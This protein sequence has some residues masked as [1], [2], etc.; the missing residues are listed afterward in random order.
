MRMLAR[1]ENNLLSL[2]P[3]VA[4]REM[5]TSLGMSR[6]GIV[7]V[8]DPALVAQVMDADAALFPK[9][10]LFVGALEG[11]V[12]D[13]MFVSSGERWRSQRRTL[14]PTFGHMHLG[15]A[16]AG[17][18]AAVADARPQLDEAAKSGARFSLD[19]TMT[20][21]TADIITRAI[22]STPRSKT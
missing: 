5:M 22:F 9:N 2:L 10:D 3:D 13:A 14:E 16:F 21:L 11:L 19:A 18:A 8:N 12:G 15:R 20:H 1:R 6:R 7:L 17:M 4:Y